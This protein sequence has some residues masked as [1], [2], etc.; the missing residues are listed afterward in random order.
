MNVS[1]PRLAHCAPL[2]FRVLGTGH[3][4]PGS[5]VDTDQLLSL[6][7]G[8]FHID[9]RSRG[10]AAARRLGVR[11]RHLSR[12]L[13][14]RHENPRPG[15]SNAELAA[16][17]IRA[18][19][20]DA[21]LGVGD[22]QYLIAHTSTPGTL[23]PPGAARVAELLGYD[24]PFVELRQACTGFANALLFAGACRESA[25][26]NALSGGAVVIAG[27]E[28]G[29][30]FFDP[31]RATESKA[32][33]VNMLQ[34]GDGAAAVVLTPQ[35]L[36]NSPRIENVYIGQLGSH[37]SPA[38]QLA[39][40]GSDHRGSPAAP[41]EFTHDFVA[42]QR[43]GLQLFQAG[44]AAAASMATEL[45]A[46]DYVI[47]HQANGRMAELLA[48]HLNIAAG[49]IFCNADRL[50]NTGSAAIWLA[51]DAL[52][53]TMRRGESALVLGAE[54]SKFMYGGFRYVHA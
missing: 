49:R 37:R 51:L 26:S 23:L 3:A 52:R 12:D 38:F 34:M 16:R 14:Q 4:L 46:F 19:L 6:A 20:A 30:V 54:A 42:I 18:A 22:V 36:A 39:A 27:S 1:L 32:Q 40:G 2:P 35:L 17:A 31:L 8:N 33:L 15:D 45:D 7:E 53:R 28:T 43:D 24:G 11:T 10:I 47:P 13:K 5:A 50:G 44:I 21:G 9:V 48:P 41:A 29:S 25:K